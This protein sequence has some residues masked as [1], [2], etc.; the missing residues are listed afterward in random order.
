VPAPRRVALDGQR[1]A[2]AHETAFEFVSE[3]ANDR[4]LLLGREDAKFLREQALVAGLEGPQRGQL[5]L[6]C[7]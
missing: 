5:L 2:A 7:H 4:D 1:G 6:Y 3:C